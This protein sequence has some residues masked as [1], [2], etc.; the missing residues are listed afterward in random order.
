MLSHKSV[1]PPPT[2]HAFEFVLA[3]LGEGAPRSG[4]DLAH[5]RRDEHL[6]RCRE[7]RDARTDVHSHAGDIGAARLDLMLRIL[8]S[9]LVDP[10]RPPRDAEAL[11]AYLRRWVGP[12]D[13]L[14]RP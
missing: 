3:A 2:W 6:S 4:D 1:Q 12:A 14:P 10:G 13:P 8:Q 11:R 9:F 5:G 7:C